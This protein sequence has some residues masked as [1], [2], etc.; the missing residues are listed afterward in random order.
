[1]TLKELLE[2]NSKGTF[3]VKHEKGTNIG[4]INNS[5]QVSLE[6][7]QKICC[8]IGWKEFYLDAFEIIAKTNKFL[9]LFVFLF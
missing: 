6:Q 9:K 2:L 5:M 8:N 7:A 1:M 3:K 4:I